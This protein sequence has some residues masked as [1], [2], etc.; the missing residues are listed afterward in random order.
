[1][2]E[3]FETKRSRTTDRLELD[4]G[5]VPKHVAVIMDGN[6]RWA[7]EKGQPRANGH[8]QGA[9]IVEQIAV[10][11]VHLGIEALTLYSFSTEN[12]KRP[13]PEI[14][15]LMH[16]YASYLE[17]IRPTLMKH[18]VKL[19]HVGKRER[20]PDNVLKELDTTMELTKDNTGMKLGL[21]LNYSGR[22][23]LVHAIKNIASEH[24]AGKIDIESIDQ[25]CVDD[26]LY[27]A[28]L[29][30]VDMVI[31]TAGEMRVSNFL[32][33]QISYAEFYV[34]DIYWPDFNESEMDNAVKAYA[35]RTR[36]FGKTDAQLKSD[37]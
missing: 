7:Q 21:A 34:T 27:T 20:L 13:Q 1:M 9:K 32:L 30:D 11:C 29:G 36:R 14:N 10:H 28:G 2:R 37:K 17:G 16:L 18:N 19:V 23:E 22:D 25:A 33:W 12:W 15:A 35:K 26:H 8:R 6:G 31:R 4:T 3:S 24:K 5:Q